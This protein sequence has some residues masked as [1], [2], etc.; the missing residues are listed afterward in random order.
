MPAGATVA[1]VLARQ[2]ER[3]RFAP[4]VAHWDSMC[5]AIAYEV[6][7]ALHDRKTA[8]AALTDAAVRV[9]ELAGRR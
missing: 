7:E 8:A 9:T 5:T 6:G 2:G 3:A 4:A 1:Q